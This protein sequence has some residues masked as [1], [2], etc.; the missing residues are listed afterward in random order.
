MHNDT[1]DGRSKINDQ[2]T[3]KALFKHKL[4]QYLS[5]TLVCEIITTPAQLHKKPVACSTTLMQASTLRF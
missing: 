4:L 1:F 5:Y 3:E 2:E